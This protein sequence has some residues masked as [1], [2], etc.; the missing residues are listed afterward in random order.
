MPSKNHYKKCPYACVRGTT[1]NVNRKKARTLA[2]T[3]EK[4]PT[5]EKEPKAERTRSVNKRIGYVLTQRGAT[6]TS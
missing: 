5:L 6:P 4:Y 1:D 3:E 2:A